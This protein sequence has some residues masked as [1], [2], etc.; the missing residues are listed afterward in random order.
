[1]KSRP[2]Y[3]DS[4]HHIEIAPDQPGRAGEWIGFAALLLG[5]GVVM[6]ALL[7]WLTGSFLMAAAMTVGMIGLMLLMGWMASG[8]LDRRR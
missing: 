1:V 6:T 8:P 3:E 2:D 4:R 7:L 5:V